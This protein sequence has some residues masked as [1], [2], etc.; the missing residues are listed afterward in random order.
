M[1]DLWKVQS[2]GIDTID[3][4]N[5]A[6]YRRYLDRFNEY[7]EKGHRRRLLYGEQDKEQSPQ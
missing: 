2:S 5:D 7:E 3:L 6:E 1:E 4:A